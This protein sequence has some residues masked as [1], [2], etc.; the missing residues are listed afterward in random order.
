MNPGK[1]KALG[2]GTPRGQSRSL[3]ATYSRYS[4]TEGTKSRAGGSELLPKCW[5]VPAVS[6]VPQGPAA[7]RHPLGRLQRE[8]DPVSQRQV[9]GGR[10]AQACVSKQGPVHHT[11][12]PLV[13]AEGRLITK[14]ITGTTHPS[15]Q[16]DSIYQTST[17]CSHHRSEE[18]EGRPAQVADTEV[19][20]NAPGRTGVPPA[21]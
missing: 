9:P 7:H 15:L 1:S 8:M 18:V 4:V 20:A 10:R 16:K 6:L 5:A 19:G 13:C 12:L 14:A 11:H 17:P 2:V 21:M 3:G